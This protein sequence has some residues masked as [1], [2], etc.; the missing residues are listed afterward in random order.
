MLQN[1][2]YNNDIKGFRMSLPITTH[3]E[4]LMNFR[5]YYLQFTQNLNEYNYKAYQEMKATK[6]GIS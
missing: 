1:E 6:E 3:K 2:N 4:P 5:K